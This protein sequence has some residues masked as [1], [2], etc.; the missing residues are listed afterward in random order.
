[1]TDVVING[2]YFAVGYTVSVSVCGLDCGDYVVAAD[3]SV[4]VPY[5]SDPD[6][7]FNGDYLV[8]FDVGPYDGNQTYG[9]ATTRLDVS[10]SSGATQ[11]IYVPVVIGFT[12]PS[13]GIPLRAMGED[14]TKTPQ[15]APLGKT[16]RNRFI[17]FLFR[18]AQGVTVGSTDAN[19]TWFPVGFRNQTLGPAGQLPMNTLFSGVWRAPI[20]EHPNFDGQIGWAITRPYAC[21]VVA[22]CNFIDT[23]ER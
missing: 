17:S 7:Q 18:N 22:Q 19:A 4:S 11:T 8:F 20:E 15:G 10:R 16:R 23:E 9:D 12:Y 6:E 5:N 2:L 13:F 14:Q 1:M 21:S 3:G